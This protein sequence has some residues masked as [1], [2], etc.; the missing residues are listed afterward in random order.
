MI[1]S[2]FVKYM[3]HSGSI[4]Q[5]TGSFLLKL[6]HYYL[7]LKMAVKTSESATATVKLVGATDDFSGSESDPDIQDSIGNE[8]RNQA[9]ESNAQSMTLKESPA[10]DIDSGSQSPSTSPRKDRFNPFNK[11]SYD[12]EKQQ[13]TQLR[14]STNSSH[15]GTCTLL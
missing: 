7:Q 11:E 10:D 9:G 6:K 8:V 13:F 2:L 12:E 15:S 1:S 14:S 3:I 5:I 4:S